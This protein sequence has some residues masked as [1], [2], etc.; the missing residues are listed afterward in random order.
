MFS[1]P[2]ASTCVDFP[3]MFQNS[4]VTKKLDPSDLVEF[5]KIQYNSA[6]FWLDEVLCSKT[7][8]TQKS[9]EFTD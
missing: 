3:A 1:V 8:K 9:I 5:G 4:I 2:I 6:K 7:P